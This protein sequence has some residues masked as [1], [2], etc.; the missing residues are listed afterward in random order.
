ML[1][2]HC[3]ASVD[4]P[5][6]DD[7]SVISE[8]GRGKESDYFAEVLTSEATYD[9]VFP[10]GP[11]THTA[12]TYGL[13]KDMLT[14]HRMMRGRI[15]V[16]QRQSQGPD[17]KPIGEEVV[18]ATVAIY[19]DGFSIASLP[20]AGTA[21]PEAVPE[22]EEQCFLWSPFSAVERHN[23]QAMVHKFSQWGLSVFKLTILRCRRGV[24]R[25][26]YFATIGPD[27]VKERNR[28]MDAMACAIGSVAASL[29][30]PHAITANPVPGVRST[31]TRILAGH[32]LYLTH[33]DVVSVV[34]CE[35]HTYLCGESRLSLYRGEWCDW[36]IMTIRFMADSVVTSRSGQ[37]CTVFTVD[38]NAFAA[39]TPDERELWLRA[40]GNIKVKL[41]FDAPDPTDEDLEVMRQSVQEQI[42][43]I[44]DRSAAEVADECAIFQPMLPQLPRGP[45]PVSPAGDADP[46]SVQNEEQPDAVGPSP[47]FGGRCLSASRLTPGSAKL[48]SVE[49][50]P[51]RA[52]SGAALTLVASTAS[53]ASREAPP[54]PL[55]LEKE[56]LAQPEP[57]PAQLQAP[58]TGVSQ[59]LVQPLMLRCFPPRGTEAADFCGSARSVPGLLDCPGLS[60]PPPDRND[61]SQHPLKHIGAL[62]AQRPD[63]DDAEARDTRFI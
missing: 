43:T 23:N 57:V 29:F 51:Q 19:A 4:A 20:Q 31:Q 14:G 34:Y 24:D 7:A 2:C 33:D 53:P 10:S 35:L 21:T 60:L 47:S 36:E 58:P 54:V 30:P 45:L 39:R 59:D 50:V 40:L 16:L 6:G 63:S 37:R 28:W 5:H 42:V 8:F 11:R 15:L 56:T 3:L 25:S 46:A 27:S 55:P 26:F 12:Q 41:M 49:P 52:A 32:L 48:P 13:S 62:A 9:N 44:S 1:S 17:G 61:V 18:E 38:R 22:A